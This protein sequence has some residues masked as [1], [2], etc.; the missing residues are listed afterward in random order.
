M[1]L[2][3]MDKW[4]KP[5]R[6]K[7]NPTS[8]DSKRMCQH[9]IRTFTGYIN[10]IQGVSEENKLNILINHVD[11]SVYEHISEAVKRTWQQ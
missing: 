6:F 2:Y 8:P 3:K 11:T 5:E 4:L 1:K 9:W 10:S 7:N